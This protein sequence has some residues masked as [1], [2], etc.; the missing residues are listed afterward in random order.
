MTSKSTTEHKSATR[1]MMGGLLKHPGSMAVATLFTVISTLLLVLPAMIIGL[2]ID[3][4]TV[5]GFTAQFTF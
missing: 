5:A 2:A 3:E 1:Y 4:L